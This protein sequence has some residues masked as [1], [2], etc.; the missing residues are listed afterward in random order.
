[1]EIK[2][3]NLVILGGGTAGWLCAA[4]LAKRLQGSPVKVT[5]IESEDIG[6]IGV[7]EA[8]IPPIRAA[9]SFL[10]IDEEQ[11][12]A[13]TSG[14]YKLGIEFVNWLRLDH[15]Y[16][17]P[18]GAYGI[19]WGGIP[20]HQHFLRYQKNGGA[21]DYQ[22]FSLTASAAKAG[23]FAST[24]R[25]EQLS[26]NWSYAFH[27]DSTLA[28]PFFREYAERLGVERVEGRVDAA[29]TDESGYITEAILADGVRV[30]GDFFIDCSG[31]RSKLLG[32][33]LGVPYEEWS[34]QLFCDTAVAAPSRRPESIP[35]YT[36]SIAKEAGWQ[37]EIP[38]SHRNGNGY[39]FSSRHL[40]LDQAKAELTNSLGDSIEAEPRVIRFKPG[41][42]QR[43]WEKNCVAIGLAAGFLEPL[44]STAIHLSQLGIFWL[45]PFLPNG[46]PCEEEVSL[47]NEQM[48]SAY[49]QAKS[50]LIL[51]Y[52]TSER[53]D[54]Q[55]WRDCA[56][57][58]I[59]D[60]LK[61]RLEVFRQTGRCFIPDGELFSQGSW[62]A[63]M[64]GQ[65]VLANQY[66]FIADI[67]KEGLVEGY[68]SKLLQVYQQE[69]SQMAEHQPP[70]CP[71]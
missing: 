67:A 30:A 23:K 4:V 42:R 18:F 6:L 51:H 26:R 17:H 61:T 56:N 59:P 34:D 12:V 16:L 39:V 20:F 58:D 10:G 31:F 35:P 62:L 57:V 5:L 25:S 60:M 70:Q 32:D 65:G 47:Y 46:R 3:N 41:K 71:G 22:A 24:T 1:M 53:R 8:T 48:T 15:S 40:D 19:D 29:S 14:S 66:P 38:L 33:T 43:F 50:F 9:L 49:E 64:M 68:M 45:L 63:V 7:G 55:F 37:W 54:T 13:A 69:L 27:F 44:E 21:A 52:V 11:F 28:A 36:R 2:L